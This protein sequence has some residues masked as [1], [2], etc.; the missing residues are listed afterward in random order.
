M[1]MGMRRIRPDAA[2]PEQLGVQWP[3]TISGRYSSLSYLKRFPIDHLKRRAFIKDIRSDPD[4]G[5]I[6]QRIIALGHKLGM[7]MWRRFETEEQ[8]EYCRN[9]VTMIRGYSCKPCRERVAALLSEHMI[10]P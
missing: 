7:R 4:D 8:R 1:M 9:R 2:R 10:C 6:V 3:S 5:A